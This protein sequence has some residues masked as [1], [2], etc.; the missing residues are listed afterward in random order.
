MSHGTRMHNHAV[1]ADHFRLPSR[2]YVQ[3]RYVAPPWW[4]IGH[5]LSVVSTGV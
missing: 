3:V 5:L 2:L 4:P 1:A